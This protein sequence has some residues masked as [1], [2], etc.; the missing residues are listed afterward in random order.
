MAEF[1]P[2]T[3]P[4]AAEAAYREALL[5]DDAGR[6][7]R[8]AR[9]MAA[10]PRPQAVVAPVSKAELAWRWR[11]YVLA[12]LATG[13]LVA[14]VLALRGL[15]PGAKPEADPRLAAAPPAASTPSAAD[16]TVLA[17]AS[18]AA[19]PAP[20]ATAR[21]QSVA[22]AVRQKPRTVVVQPVV[23]AE[24]GLPER[25]GESEAVSATAVEPAK[26]A[27]EM[28][29]PVAAAPAPIAA[30]PKM[31]AIAPAAE[32]WAR[33]DVASGGATAQAGRLA[34]SLAAS[35]GADTGLLTAV[36]Q[37]DLAAARAALQAGVPVHQRDAQ[38]R[39]AL[40][41]AAR[42]GSREVVD[43]LLAAGARKA[44]R[45]A[46]GWTAAD[47]AQAQGHGKLAERLR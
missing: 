26:P 5:A 4:D 31:A 38:G 40:M 11:P 29:L 35:E 10:L 33:S 43:L 17:Q 37:G 25:R 3:P 24:S 19:E 16:A 8:R 23:V 2:M 47:H 32:A 14:A 28:P 6:E 30:A 15:P 1:D 27:A 44:D 9:L 22:K 42:N 21:P 41:L 46:Q 34:R 7:R 39:T 13:L 20:A 18:P 12:A 36:S 45:D